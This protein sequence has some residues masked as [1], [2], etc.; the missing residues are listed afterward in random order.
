MSAK[1]KEETF[2]K[3]ELFSSDVSTP[4]SRPMLCF[5]KVSTTR[6]KHCGGFFYGDCV[7]GKGSKCDY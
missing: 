3:R 4:L 5:Y 1:D 6:V 7:W 2:L